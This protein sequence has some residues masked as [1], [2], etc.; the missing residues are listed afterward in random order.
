[1]RPLL[2][3]YLDSRSPRCYNTYKFLC[4]EDTMTTYTFPYGDGA[5]IAQ[6]DERQVLGVLRGN[7]TPPLP[8]IPT[9]ALGGVKPSY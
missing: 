6:L 4:R 2:R 5:V 9:G 3:K 7:H 8:H 1:M